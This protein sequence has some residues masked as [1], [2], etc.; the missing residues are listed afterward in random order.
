MRLSIPAVVATFALGLATIPASAQT[1]V[2][3]GTGISKARSSSFSSSRSSSNSNAISANRNSANAGVGSSGNSS[4]T[5]NTNV[6]GNAPAVFAPGM[7]AAGI[8]SC[9]GSIS[10]GGSAVGG[11]GALG[12][13]W[14]DGP[15]NKRLNARTLWAFGQREAALQQLCLDDEMALAMSSAGIRCRVGHYA[16]V[17]V[18]T[19]GAPPPPAY[20]LSMRADAAPA[21]AS[22]AVFTDRKGRSYTEAACGSHGAVKTTEKGVC[23]RLASN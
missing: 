5:T 23:A 9:N 15:C 17:R 6:Q 12:F 13:P 4:I 22:H 14:Q 11:G 20:P 10:L 19:Y 8:E 2:G 3:V 1:A 7:S 21:H 18:A 16:E